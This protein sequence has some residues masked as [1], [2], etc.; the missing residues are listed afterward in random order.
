[1]LYLKNTTV[2]VIFFFVLSSCKKGDG[3]SPS[4]SGAPTNLAV[5]AVAST[6]GSG[7]V[8]F[9]ATAL[10]AATYVYEFGNGVILTVP[11]GITNYQYTTVGNITYT[12]IVTA[13]SSSGQ[14]VTTS[15]Q[16]TVNVLAVP[17][18]LFWSDEFNT[19]GAPDPAK[20]GYDIGTGSG[21]WGNNELQYYTNRPENVIVQGGLLKIKAIKENY[22]GSAYTSSRL[23]SKDKFSFT[24]GTVEARVKIP[25]GVGTWPAVWM[26]GNTV[27]TVGWPACGE[28][29]I[30]E[31]RGSELN[32]IFGTLHYPG[33][34]GGNGNGNTIVIANATTQFHIYTLDWSATTIKISVDGQLFH[35]VANSGS[36]PFNQDFFLLLN[37]A[38][39]GNFGGPVDPAF[40]NATMEVD[41]IRVYK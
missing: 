9:T 14:S 10:N 6:D 34:S 20:W 8:S 18:T 19:D 25:A 39:G 36:I 16:V 27:N 22:S 35:T 32:K 41:Y 3:N 29:D 21:G 37:V 24:Y 5:S 1:M 13:R 2:L 11:S 15:I 7:K 31:H 28:A 33:H 26:L 23:L 12:V 30:M 38:M 40:T 17:P 4:T